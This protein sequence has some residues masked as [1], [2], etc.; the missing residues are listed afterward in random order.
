LLEVLVCYNIVEGLAD[1][2]EDQLPSTEE[3]LFAIDTISLPRKLVVARFQ[4]DRPSPYPNWFYYYTKGDIEVDD[5]HVMLP[6][7]SLRQNKCTSS[8][9][10][11]RQSPRF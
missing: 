5:T 10:G 7:L 4:G 1:E 2:E 11:L 6:R 9:W 8:M 3:D